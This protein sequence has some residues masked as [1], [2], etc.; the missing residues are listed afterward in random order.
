MDYN[1]NS[2]IGIPIPFPELPNP[3]HRCLVNISLG[4]G[5]VSSG[6]KPLSIKFYDTK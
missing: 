5:L 1:S 2:G 4:N 3:A 6:N